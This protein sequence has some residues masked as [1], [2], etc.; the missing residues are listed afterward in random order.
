M[1]RM[2]EGAQVSIC[3]SGRR[4]LDLSARAASTRSGSMKLL[5]AAFLAL[6][7]LL[8]P[9]GTL[10]DAG[11]AD[12]VT[13]SFDGIEAADEQGSVTAASS[14]CE[15]PNRA[16]SGHCSS[17]TALPPPEPAPFAVGTASARLHLVSAL[18]LGSREAEALL[19]PPRFS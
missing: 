9:F 6:S 18:C 17:Y 11:T 3:R 4:V 10:A 1:D 8:A 5:A 19:E 12:A 16:G 7:V 13:H 14:C 15:S 2:G